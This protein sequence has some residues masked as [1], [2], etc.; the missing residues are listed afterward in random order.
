M[1][2]SSIGFPLPY[3]QLCGKVQEMGAQHQLRKSVHREEWKKGTM[4]SGQRVLL[5]VL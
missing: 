1:D 3:T 2:V 4:W 5:S